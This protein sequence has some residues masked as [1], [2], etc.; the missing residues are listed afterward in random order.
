M[1]NR[2]RCRQVRLQDAHP[3]L[4]L[5]AIA[6]ARTNTP[7]L[8]ALQL[9]AQSSLPAVGYSPP[10]ALGRILLAVFGMAILLLVR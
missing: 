10:F 8:G 4:L 1:T 5:G 7:A 3:T 2:P 9:A 6:G